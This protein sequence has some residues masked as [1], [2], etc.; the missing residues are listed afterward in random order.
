MSTTRLETGF[1]VMIDELLSSPRERA[2]V[3]AAHLRAV[4]AHFYDI[5][6][7]V[8]Q[9]LPFEDI[10]ALM[11]QATGLDFTGAALEAQYREIAHR[12]ARRP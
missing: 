1:S 5:F 11:T 6:R 10:A 9:D 4:E 12:K 3:E 2:A 8:D 7:A